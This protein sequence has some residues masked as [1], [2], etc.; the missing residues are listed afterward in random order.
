VADRADHH[1]ADHDDGT[2]SGGSDDRRT[3]AERA[4]DR[5]HRT[6]WG[7]TVEEPADHEGTGPGAE[8]GRAARIGLVAA[9]ILAIVVYLLVPDAPTDAAG[10]VIDLGH[11]GRATAAVGVLMAVWWMTEALHV[12]A[13]A[14]V[15]IALLPLLDAT[16]LDATASAYGDPLIFLFLGGFLIAFSLQRWGTERRLA[17]KVLGIAGSR[18]TVVVAAFMGVTAGLSM[19]VSNTATVAMMLPIALSVIDLA[20]PDGRDALTTEGARGRNF[21]RSLLL[22]VAVSASIGGVGSIIGSPPNLFLASYAREN[23]GVDIGFAQWLLLGLPLVAVFLPLSW[24]LLTRVLFPPDI[25]PERLAGITERDD[26]RPGPM[27]RAEWT[28]LAVFLATAAAWVTRPLLQDLTIGGARPL[29]HLDDAGIAILAGIV[30][31]VVP[32]DKAGTRA[33]DWA[34]AVKLPWGILLLFGGGLALAG[35]ITATGLDQYLGSFVADV[36]LHPILIIAVV[37]A[38]VVFL[39]EMTSN[40]ATAAALIPIV[41]AVAPG[42]GLHPLA[43]AV[44]VAMAASLAFMLPVATPPNAIVFGSGHID[45]SDMMRTGLR[46]NL[47]SIVLVTAT[48][49]LVALPVLGVDLRL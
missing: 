32:V 40:T 6:T 26:I 46:L 25:D 19:W 9:P 23:L 13:T 1:Q 21:A 39:T 41:S 33:L 28:V 49:V 45:L 20:V 47:A 12:S 4:A 14:L 16:D 42:L 10:D 15:P 29:E 35:A 37:T 38:G 44:P 7:V 34:T 5:R 2:R 8:R 36:D 48:T 43:L 17:L 3:H 24:L 30:L 31:F 18:P 27:G 11:A 22:G